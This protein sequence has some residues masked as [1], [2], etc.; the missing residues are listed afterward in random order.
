MNVNLNLPDK[1]SG[2]LSEF[3]I[4]LEHY[5]K[6]IAHQEENMPKFVTREDTLVV[7]ELSKAIKSQILSIC[8]G[9]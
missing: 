4:A 5:N 9:L 6:E 3:V 7:D 8:F 1:Y 2:H